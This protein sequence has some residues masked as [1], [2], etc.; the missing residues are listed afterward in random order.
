MSETTKLPLSS[1]WLLISFAAVNAVMF[2]PAL[3]GISDYFKVSDKVAQL[4]VT[5]FLLGYAIGQL[6]YGPLS[7]RFGR[8]PALYIGISIQI[9]SSLTCILAGYVHEFSVLVI[10][11]FLLAIGS[12]VGLKVSVTMVNECYPPQQ[13]SQTLSILMLAFAVAPGL[14]VAL[15]GVLNENYGWMSCFYAGAIYGIILLP[16]AASLPETLAQK[17]VKGLQWKHLIHA[18]GHEFSQMKIIAGGCLVGVNG[19]LFYIFAA[20]VPFIAIDLSGM[21]SQEY[22]F[23]NMIPLAGLAL[24]SLVS[25]KLTQRYTLMV[26]IKIGIGIATTGVVLMLI[27]VALQLPILISIFFTMFIVSAGQIMVLANASTTAM[28]LAKDKAHG[29]AVV[30]FIAILLSTIGVVSLGAFKTRP[31]YLPLIYMGFCL[32]S[33]LMYSILSKRE[34][35]TTTSNVV[36][37]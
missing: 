21:T 23:A 11:R 27:L 4:S 19:A 36:L 3:P 16:L 31:I 8:K 37:L 10:A 13:A 17:D 9:I 12:G 14:S 30:N 7:N 20:M 32:F 33:M 22:G 24:G 6:L 35:K 18:Y 26:I 28:S 5:L 29:S 25:A 2:T 34:G 15:G 1:L